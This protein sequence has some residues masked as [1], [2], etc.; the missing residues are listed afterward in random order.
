MGAFLAQLWE[1]G[2]WEVEVG[3]QSVRP[4]RFNPPVNLH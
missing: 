3:G 1:S 4:R 2:N